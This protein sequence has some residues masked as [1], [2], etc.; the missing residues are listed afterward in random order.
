MPETTRT[1]L[2]AESPRKNRHSTRYSMSLMTV[3]VNESLQ[4]LK[5]HFLL[6][7]EC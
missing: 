3:L 4:E 5:N 7:V 2:Q 6:T 1:Q